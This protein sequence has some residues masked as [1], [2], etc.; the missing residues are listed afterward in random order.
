MVDIN[1]TELKVGDEVCYV[2]GKN[3]SA[4]LKIGNITKIY[5]SRQHGIDEECSVDGNAHI[6]P[7]RIMR[8]KNEVE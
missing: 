6:Y 7:S 1:G 8:I 5:P 4:K 3:A 2:Y